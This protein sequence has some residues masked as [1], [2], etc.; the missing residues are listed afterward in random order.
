MDGKV[1]DIEKGANKKAPFG[2]VQ[3]IERKQHKAPGT[4]FEMD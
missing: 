1:L 4:W 3:Q 2:N